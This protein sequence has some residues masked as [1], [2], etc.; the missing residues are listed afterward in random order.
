MVSLNW[1][2]GSQISAGLVDPGGMLMSTKSSAAKM[3]AAESL[4]R[5]P[6]RWMPDALD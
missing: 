6:E 5:K 1:M 3:T 2:V 4:A